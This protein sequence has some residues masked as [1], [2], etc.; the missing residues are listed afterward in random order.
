M[1]KEY[2]WIKI[3]QIGKSKSGKTLI[4]SVV[5]KLWAETLGYIKWKPS[6]RKYNFET[7]GIISLEEECMEDISKFLRELKKV[8]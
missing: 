2:K 4:F 5:N 7:I 8:V 6:Y 3:K 1:E